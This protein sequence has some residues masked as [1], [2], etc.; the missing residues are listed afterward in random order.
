MALK[1]GFVFYMQLC[2]YVR[3]LGKLFKMHLAGLLL[4]YACACGQIQLIHVT[5]CGPG[6]FPGTACTVPATGSGNLIV[7]GWQIAGGADTSAIITSITD[8]V[9]NVYSE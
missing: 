8:N 3:F 4:C 7:V 6:A 2:D 5:N 9:G 1:K